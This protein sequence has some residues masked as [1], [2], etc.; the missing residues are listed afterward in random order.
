[1][2]AE[3]YK[4]SI[5]V[6]FA[7]LTF[8]G[9]INL[10]GEWDSPTTRLNAVGLEVSRATAGTQT[11]SV[12]KLDSSQEI[13][14]D[15][16]P[17]GARGIELEYSGKVLED[18][19]LGL[20]RSNQP[21]GYVLATQFESTGA[22]RVFPCLDRPDQK[23]VFDVD[24]T[25]DPG[26]EVIF[27]MPGSD[28][29]M[30]DGRKWV[31]FP[32]TPRMSTY[33]V[34]LA[35]GKFDVLR[36]EGP[37]T[38]L[39]AWT[40]PGDAEKGRFALN[41]SRRVLQQFEKYYDVPYPLPKLDLVSLRDF[42]AGAMENWGAIS[43]R[44]RYVLADEHTTAGLRRAISLVTA[45]EIAHQ[46]FGDLVTMQWWDDIW[47]NESFA[48]FMA[49]KVLDQ[50]GDSP[51]IWSDF[52]L[53]EMAGAL[54][55]DSLEST[56]PIRQ[57][58]DSPEEIDQVFDEI[59]YGKG[60]SVLRMLE[61]FV[62]P[63]GFRQGVHDYLVKFQYGN[64]RGEDLWAA[65]EAAA[66]QPVSDLM[67]RWVERPG[68]PVLIV[69]R[70]PDGLHLEQRRFSI[71]GEHP[72]QF[73]PLP[74]VART[75]G[76]SVRMLMT[77]PE[78]TLS[79]TTEADIFLNEDALGFYRVLYDGP[80]YDRILQQFK[81]LPPSE[82]W[83]VTEDLFSFLLSGDASFD[84]WMSFV[85]LT[86]DE[87]DALVVTGVMHQLGQL[88]LPLYDDPTFVDL[89]R[90]FHAAQTR[91]LGLESKPGETDMDRRLRE[92]ITRGRI[93]L[94][95]DFAKEI[96]PKFAQFDQLNP[97]IRQAVAMAYAQVEGSRVAD[98]LWKRLREGDDAEQSQ[99]ARA[100][101]SFDDPAAVRAT[102]D[103]A[104]QGEMPWGTVLWALI[105]VIRHP[106]ARPVLWQWYL[107]H[108][109]SFNQA[110][111]GTSTLPLAYEYLVAA[112]GTDDLQ[113]IRDY[114]AQNPVAGAERGVQK[115]LEYAELFAKLHDRGE[116]EE[117]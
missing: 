41:V 86:L 49:Y 106:E 5:D 68:H 37:G 60:A 9:K 55:G 28:T 34:F 19:L 110:W 47:L 45:H 13:Q 66:H 58:V 35:I 52:L 4:L 10:R 42:G 73:W 78:I 97:D 98:E 53:M 117:P 23:A 8:R 22:R 77:G 27:N 96:A 40:P 91:R 17:S 1:V 103:R 31:Q 74:L 89:Y 92:S 3:E 25:V 115:G 114:F 2:K 65:L 59:S 83:L 14:L 30:V 75:G 70:G 112:E 79:V 82:R 26:L 39:A 12:T 18:A 71:S 7:H 50:L 104:S 76:K 88:L 85:E 116:T 95:P 102:L 38:E 33:L 87:S 43:S 15:G 72:R 54:L 62:G 64:A 109:E 51:G 21:P 81:D 11:L 111:I 105:E 56:H 94:D 84:R 6:D 99:M 24:V 67:R 57:P 100:L 63:D 93:I 32:K 90:R 48:S 107:V 36:G 46:W 29:T 16:V 101:V 61:A 20:Y 69:H 113:G 80:T 108:R 44:E